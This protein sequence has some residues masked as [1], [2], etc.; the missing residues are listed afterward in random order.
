MEQVKAGPEGEKWVMPN[1]PASLMAAT[2][3]ERVAMVAANLSR[4][5]LPA[6]ECVI[7]AYEIIRWAAVGHGYLMGDPNSRINRW[8][9]LLSDYIRGE[10]MR[11]ST[12]EDINSALAH[13]KWDEKNNPTPLTYVDALAAIDPKG[14]RTRRREP[15]II[16]WME[17]IGL[18]K[19]PQEAK[20]ILNGW[21]DANEVPF[22]EYD[23]AYYS[24]REWMKC[25]TSSQNA[26]K[27]KKK[28][29]TQ[30]QESSQPT[31][32]RKGKRGVSKRSD[33]KRRRAKHS[34]IVGKGR[35]YDNGHQKIPKKLLE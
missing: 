35:G 4:S 31:P 6:H 24:F 17:A 28:K 32:K 23:F 30:K 10:E 7:K 19:S 20:K 16:E 12:M 33:D 13:V 15:R 29:L 25:K 5:D 2:S 27:G 3:V 9:A 1:E 18:V 34:G 11:E 26:A 8:T 22:K 14:D 21:R